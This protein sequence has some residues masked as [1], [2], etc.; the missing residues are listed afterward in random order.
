MCYYRN[1]PVTTRLP[2]SHLPSMRLLGGG[3]S[4][5]EEGA[6]SWLQHRSLRTEHEMTERTPLSIMVLFYH[7]GM[8][9]AFLSPYGVLEM[10]ITDL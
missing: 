9:L 6:A 3:A 2:L 4:R 10:A 7:S 1:A 8:A 5:S